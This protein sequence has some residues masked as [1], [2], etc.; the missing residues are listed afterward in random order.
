MTHTTLDSLDDADV[1]DGY[2]DGRR[3]EPEPGDNRSLAYCHGWRN[4]R[5]D[6]GH[7]QPSREQMALVRLVIAR[8]GGWIGQ[9]PGNP[10]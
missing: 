7:A 6:G 10:G 8:P 1:L 5:V 9:L 2:R 4:G 3:N